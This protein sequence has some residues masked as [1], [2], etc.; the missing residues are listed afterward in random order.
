MYKYSFIGERGKILNISAEDYLYFT[1]YLI[2]KHYND[3]LTFKCRSTNCFVYIRHN[4]TE[5]G[6]SLLPETVFYCFENAFRTGT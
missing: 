5:V 1:K 6:K 3:M 2:S 4:G